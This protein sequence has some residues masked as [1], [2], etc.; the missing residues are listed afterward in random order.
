MADQYVDPRDWPSEGRAL[1]RTDVALI[2]AEVL[3][4]QPTVTAP[5]PWTP[6][7]VGAMLSAAGGL[8]TTI[9][10]G[11]TQIL[12]SGQQTRDEIKRAITEHAAVESAARDEVT[13]RLSRAEREQRW[14]A[15]GLCVANGRPLHSS[16]PCDLTLASQSPGPGATVREAYG[17]V[18]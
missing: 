11:I 18:P 3:A 15:A 17:R 8:V 7:A 9:V 10:I 12:G 2:V 16:Q 5:S 14:T 4:A 1:T 13:E 6:K